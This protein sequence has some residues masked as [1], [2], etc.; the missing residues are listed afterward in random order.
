MLF[1]GYDKPVFGSLAA[2]EVGLDSMRHEC[3]LF[4][5]W[6]NQLERLSSN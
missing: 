2:L 4:D 5:E 3:K 6:L 1:K